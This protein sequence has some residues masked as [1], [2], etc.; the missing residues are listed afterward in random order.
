MDVYILP[1]RVITTAL[2]GVTT[3]PFCCVIIVVPPRE[4]ATAVLGALFGG[5]NLLNDIFFIYSRLILCN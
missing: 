1:A 3:A 4:G 5:G 2:F